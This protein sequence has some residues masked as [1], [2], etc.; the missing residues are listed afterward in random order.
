MHVSFLAYEP[1]DLPKKATPKNKKKVSKINSIL[2]AATAIFSSK[3]S[4]VFFSIK[5]KF[6]FSLKTR[7]LNQNQNNTHHEL[8]SATIK[9]GKLAVN[10]QISLDVPSLIW[11]LAAHKACVACLFT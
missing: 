6:D 2:L 1:A 4:L 9:G 5:C 8:A 11:L 7:N 3:L 10:T